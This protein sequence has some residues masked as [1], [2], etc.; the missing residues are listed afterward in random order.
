MFVHIRLSAVLSLNVST[1]KVDNFIIF[2]VGD[3]RPQNG[4]N[5][6]LDIDL[7]EA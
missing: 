2:L 3:E 5:L 1:S 7:E 6:L 4:A